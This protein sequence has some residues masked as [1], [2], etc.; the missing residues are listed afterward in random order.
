[1]PPSDMAAVIDQAARS[2]WIYYVNT[3]GLIRYYM[4]PET[5]TSESSQGDKPYEGPHSVQVG[6]VDV[7]AN[8]EQPKLAVVDYK[9]SG[10][11][12]EVSTIQNLNMLLW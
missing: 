9:P 5:G 3:D 1:M 2:W 8:A 10:G 7:K 12:L 6:G 4:G 11:A